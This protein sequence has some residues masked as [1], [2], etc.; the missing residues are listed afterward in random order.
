MARRSTEIRRGYARCSIGNYSVCVECPGD[1]LALCQLGTLIV[2]FW[3]VFR[4]AT[5]VRAAE[6]TRASTLKDRGCVG[7]GRSR[8][9]KSPV[10]ERLIVRTTA[11][12]CSSR[13]PR[14]FSQSRARVPPAT[15]VW[16]VSVEPTGRGQPAGLNNPGCVAG[17]GLAGTPLETRR[18]R[19][20]GGT[21]RR[22]RSHRKL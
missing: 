12:S 2:P 5:D 20:A 17:L 3:H 6:N 21:P 22:A 13:Y 8:M 1:F 7:Q 19:E 11:A 15:G 14:T 9:D 10:S 4:A 16:T 18:H